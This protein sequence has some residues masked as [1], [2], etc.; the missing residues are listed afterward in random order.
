LRGIVLGTVSRGPGP[1]STSGRRSL[2]VMRVAAS[3]DSDVR[4]SWAGAQL[5][6]EVHET[7]GEVRGATISGA[8]DVAAP[9]A[10]GRASRTTMLPSV[11]VRLAWYIARSASRNRN[12][13]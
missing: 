5:S 2:A 9:R 8:V 3:K 13:G 11:P 6:G 1:K 12:A 4:G 10:V 7:S